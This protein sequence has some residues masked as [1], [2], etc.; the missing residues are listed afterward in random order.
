MTWSPDSARLVTAGYTKEYTGD[1][2][3]IWEAV[4][5]RLLTAFSSARMPTVWSPDR[6]YLAAVSTKGVEV[7]VVANERSLITLASHTSD[8]QGLAWSPDGARLLLWHSKADQES[9]EQRS[10]T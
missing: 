2:A 5:G 1:V 7:W 3:Q 10:G 6:A 9:T 8:T 4:S